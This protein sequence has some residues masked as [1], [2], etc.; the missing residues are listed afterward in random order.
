MHEAMASV[1]EPKFSTHFSMKGSGNGQDARL[2]AA[3]CSM[4]ACE[5]ETCS[6]LEA[7]LRAGAVNDSA[8]KSQ[9][10]MG[11]P[12]R[13][14]IRLYHTVRYLRWEQVVF[15]VYRHLY[16]PP[17]QCWPHV[18]RRPLQ[19]LWSDPVVK[20]ARLHRPWLFEFLNVRRDC[21]FPGDW[22]NQAMEKLWLYNLHYFDD[23][24]GLGAGSRRRLHSALI[25]RW[26]E[27][28][29]PGFGNGWEPYPLSLRLVNWIKWILAG[30]DCSGSMEQSLATQAK[31]LSGRLEY[32]LLGNHLF[33]NGKAL[34]FAGL[35]FQGPD[36]QSLLTIG[37]Q[38]IEREL[39]EQILADGGHFERSPMYHAIILEDLLDLINITRAFA[40][41]VPEH[42]L[43]LAR[44]MLVWLAVMTHPDGEVSFF[45]DC[46]AGIA[47][48][49]ADLA[50]YG[51]RIGL[52]PVLLPEAR[53]STL[54][55]SG[56]IRVAD[57]EAIFLLDVAPVGP[58]YLPGHAHADTLSFEWSLYGHR[59]V[60]NSGTSCYGTSAERLRQRGTAAHSTV[61]VA[62]L[63][64][65]EVWGGFRVAR[66]ANPFRL[67]IEKYDHEVVVRCGHDGYRRLPG[68]PVHRRQ[69]KFGQGRL[70]IRDQIE[71][72][73]L[74]ATARYHL[75]PAIE[76]R[77][78]GQQGILSLPN[79]R[80]VCWR[81][82]GG[83]AHL[84]ESSYHPEFGVSIPS[85]CLELPFQDGMAII[86]FTW[87]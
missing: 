50:T 68:K 77:G 6:P 4:R 15:R 67:V 13:R 64:S 10:P 18:D 52:D 29:P 8:S 21:S 69:W 53:V 87:D 55:E 74:S 38:I 27:D 25:H 32:H 79:N 11:S 61:D 66:R 57:R 23:L 45:N 81:A 73:P 35:F 62:G 86:T 3:G 59:L 7:S 58:D 1:H 41:P 82:E 56:Y 63:D 37:Q 46:A 17:I 30:N 36:A 75:H 24:Q 49:F 20:P 40:R 70:E 71:G 65:S 33:A 51:N 44:R 85:R 78:E 72:R 16:R 19:G 83:S 9:R 12:L 2:L 42:W 26:I 43:E 60:V 39:R 5:Q 14:V 31:F 84:A 22:N 34:V 48:S 80:Q 47:P 28:N 54:G 76:A